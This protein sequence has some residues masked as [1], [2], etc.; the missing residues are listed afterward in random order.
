MSRRN[1]YI[2]LGDAI[3]Q[4]FRQENLDEKYSVHAVRNAWEE[5]AGPLIARHTREIRCHKKVLFVSVTS[6]IIRTELSYNKQS[7][8]DKINQFCGRKLVEEIVLK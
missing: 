2:K 7:L 1:S 6:D 3:S 5:I 8:I 4:L